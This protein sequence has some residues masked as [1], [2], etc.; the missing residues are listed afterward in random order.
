MN[1]LSRMS[2]KSPW[3]YRIN[4]GSCNGCDVELAT[5][6]CIPRYDVER[7]GC[8]Y[9]GSPKHA[10]I[11]L[12]TGPLTARVKDKVLRVYEEIPDPKV[13]VAIGVCPISGGVFRE[14]YSI[15]GPIDRYLPVDVN[16][17]GCPPRPQAI[18]EGIAKAIEIWAGRI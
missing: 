11:V 15:V 2:K 8:Q 16:V 1:F 3:L 17:P 4:A 7:L 9:C 10:D 13:T 18:I 12:V 5:T 14:S 6:A